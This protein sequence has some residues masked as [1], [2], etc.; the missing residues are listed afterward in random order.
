MSPYMHDDSVHNL[1][2]SQ[3]IVEEILKRLQP[4]SV[5][6]F[7]CGLGTFLNVFKKNG[8]REVLGIDGSW[9][10]KNKLYQYIDPKEFLEHDLE[11]EISLNK[12]YD[13]V[14][15]LEVAEHLSENAA[16]TFIQN[17]LQAGELIVFSAAIPLQGGQDHINEQWLT[18]WE[19]KFAKQHYVI[20]DILRPIFWNR[21]DIFWW[22]KQNMVLVTPKDYQIPFKHQAVPMRNIVHYE[23]YETKAKEAQLFSDLITGKKKTKF[24][25]K[26]LLKSILG[27]QLSEKI[28]HVVNRMRKTTH[29]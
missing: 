23:L 8:V 18:Y 27:H 7:G 11:K 24:Y 25:L 3:P 10:D 22:Y 14:I 29:K 16:D 20:H 28:S 2:T 15:S 6:D 17:L 19:E 1:K 4:K 5:V 21:P 12:K 9:V 26:Q 13:L